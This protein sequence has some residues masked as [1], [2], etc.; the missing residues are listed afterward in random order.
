LLVVALSAAAVL[1]VFAWERYGGG[2]TWPA[3]ITNFS[4]TCLAFLVALAW[5]R[6]Q[7]AFLD[8]K[9]IEAEQRRDEAEALAEQ[10]RRMTEATRRFSAIA[11]ELERIQAS[12]QRAEAEQHRYKY[13]FPD[14]P[15]GSWR[16]AS[17][18]LGLIMADYGLMADLATFYGHVGELQW[19]LRFKAEPSTAEES[20]NPII[21]GLVQA[22]LADVAE[23]LPQVRRQVQEPDVE[24]VL[25]QTAGGTV[26]ARRQY[27]AA[28]RIVDA[29][30]F[31]GPADTP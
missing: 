7:R 2:V 13:F 1:P 19:R 31:G 3:L 22:M 27:T 17:A 6:R 20:L 14:L 4:A 23:L 15:S 21:D 12:L 28:I 5:D 11:L 30:L 16:A 25:T 24:P 9:E 26:V 29:P 10:T 18:P 8:R